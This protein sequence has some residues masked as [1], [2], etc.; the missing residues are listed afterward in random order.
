[1]HNNAEYANWCQSR[2]KRLEIPLNA[3]ELTKVEATVIADIGCE[4]P[5]I[6]YDHHNGM[7]LMLLQSH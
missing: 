4:I 6:N 2:P 3:P 7:L 1:M 5:R